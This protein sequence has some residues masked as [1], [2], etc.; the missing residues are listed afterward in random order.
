MSEIV[1]RIA[2][3]LQQI[4]VQVPV[5]TNLALYSL[6]WTILSGRL[7]LTRGALFPALLDLGLPNEAV[8]RAQAAL[9]YGRWQFTQLLSA[10]QLV[11][12]VEGRFYPHTYAGYRPVPVDLVGFFRP[13]LV[14]CVSKHYHSQ[15]DKALP[16]V[17]LG[18]SGPVGTVGRMRLCLPRH[19]VRTE[20]EDRTDT[21]RMRRTL[22]VVGKS[23]APQEVAI[24]DRQFTLALMQACGVAR[25]VVRAPKQLYRP[26]KPPACLQRT[27]TPPRIW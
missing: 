25:Y 22:T 21:D 10:W 26:K 2:S 8:R 18:L 20:P 9:A 27:R 5:G 3:L 23:L 19:I 13:R 24:G 1:Y 4:L 17:V 11:V 16:A 12:A 14:G 7:L 6:L 15:A